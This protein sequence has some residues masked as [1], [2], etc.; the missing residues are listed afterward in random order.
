M[1]QAKMKEKTPNEIKSSTF[2]EDG[3]G[4]KLEPV[5]ANLHPTRT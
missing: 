5:L 3:E 1:R 4:H 2:G